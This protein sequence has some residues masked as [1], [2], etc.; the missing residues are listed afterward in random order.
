[1]SLTSE[2]LV[3]RFQQVD[4]DCSQV[5]AGSIFDEALFILG[6]VYRVFRQSHQTS[7]IGYAPSVAFNREHGDISFH[8]F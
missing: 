8:A 2:L 1:M 3:Q 5:A 7:A 4:L 6:E